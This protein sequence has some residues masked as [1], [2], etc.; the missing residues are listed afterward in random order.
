MAR[1]DAV[2]LYL[3]PKVHSI[4]RQ[5]QS[6]MESVCAKLEGI[7]LQVTGA[8]ITSSYQIYCQYRVPRS[9][10]HVTAL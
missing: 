7:S 3:H 9:L 5:I 1:A 10:R 8:S 2:A 6:H 4:A